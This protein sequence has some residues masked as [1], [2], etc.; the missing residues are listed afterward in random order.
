[1]AAGHGRHAQLLAARGLRVE[2]IDR[3][4]QALAALAAIAGVTPIAADIESGPWPRAGRTYD[5]V[6]VT[7]YL[8]R[9]R[10]PDIAAA[11]G[12]GGILIYETFAVG[13]ETLGKPSNAMFLLRRGEL[14]DWAR[15]AGLAVLGFESGRVQSPRP[16]IVERICAWRAGGSTLPPAID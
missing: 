3:D 14:L 13:N 16:A 7:N 4:P 8:W 10:L 2:A 6:V 12:E 9:E 15:A 5:G 1:M 11:L